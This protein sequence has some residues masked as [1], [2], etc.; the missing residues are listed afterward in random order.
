VLTRRFKALEIRSQ[1]AMPLAT[2]GEYVDEATALRVQVA[3]AALQV[4]R[5]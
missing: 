4:I 5:A 1:K 3:P 2:D